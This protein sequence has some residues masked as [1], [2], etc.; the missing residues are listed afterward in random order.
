MVDFELSSNP[1]TQQSAEKEKN[2]KTS[3]HHRTR[4]KKLIRILR[5]KAFWGEDTS[6]IRGAMSRELGHMAIPDGFSVPKSGENPKK[7]GEIPSQNS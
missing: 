2:I 7:H 6:E 3:K 5:L 4:K 1:A